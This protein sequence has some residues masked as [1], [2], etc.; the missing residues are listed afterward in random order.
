MTARHLLAA[1]VVVVGVGLAAATLAKPVTYTMPP[2]TSTLNKTGDQ[3]FLRTEI[4]C[5]VCHS[6]D[7]ITTQPPGKGKEFW[8]AEVN[9]MV[10]VY[11]AAITEPERPA[12]IDYL[13]AS[14]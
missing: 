11:G 7:Y 12:I 4:V 9:K 2:E 10:T 14:Y 8:T 13:T 6:R 3:G 5:V 1:L